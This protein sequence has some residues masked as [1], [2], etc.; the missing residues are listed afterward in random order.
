M[1]RVDILIPKIPKFDKD[2]PEIV[3]VLDKIRMELEK[4]GRKYDEFCWFV[5]EYPRFYRHHTNN[6]EYRIQSIHRLYEYHRKEF[7]K[8]VNLE[9]HKHTVEMADY[10]V[11]SSSIYWD[12]EALLNA[13]S[14]ALDILARISGIAYPTQTPIT[15]ND[16]VKKKDLNGIVDLFRQAK[17]DWID[18][19]KAY[20]DCFVHWTPV[21]S[22]V[23][24][25]AY[26]LSKNWKMWCK[27]P[28]NPKTKTAVVFKFSRKVDLLRYSISIH[29]NLVKLDYQIAKQMQELYTAGEFPK[30]INNLFFL[31]NREKK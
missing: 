14:S 26:R 29:N 17:V 20:R 8:R 2:F 4:K 31:G 5:R 15:F 22:T 28:T 13:T 10:S 19:M 12:F 9:E 6:L 16:L 25:R 30:R 7:R 21:D 3:P 27:I 23:F 1:N 18:E 11:L 24:I